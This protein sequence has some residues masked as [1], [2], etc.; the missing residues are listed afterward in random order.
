[1]NNLIIWSKDRAAQLD[2]LIRTIDSQPYQ[3]FEI[4][5]VVYKST[6]KEFD[7][8]YKILRKIYPHVFFWSEKWDSF[9]H[10]TK[11]LVDGDSVF[12]STDDT[13]LYSN[14]PSKLPYINYGECFSLR[15]G[16]NTIVQNCHT[17]ELQEPLN[18]FVDNGMFIAWN[19]HLYQATSNYGYCFGLDMCGYNATQ[20]R[21]IFKQINFKTTNELESR[22]FNY[23]SGIT[24]MNSFR[25]S[26][27][28]NIPFN[29]ISGVTACMSNTPSL[30]QLNTDFLDGKRLQYDISVKVQ[31]CH[32]EIP[33]W[34]R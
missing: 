25:K 19:P 12:F 2:L 31:G 33:L 24:V 27:A 30:S 21:N 15:L 23:R 26:V 29:N 8:G 5:D 34:M 16:T 28:V 6:T 4:I 22:L 3:P 20:I 9:E 1:M 18:K 13:I 14:L 11:S 7:D 10:H 32:Q 17:G